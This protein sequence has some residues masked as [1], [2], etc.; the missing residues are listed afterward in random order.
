MADKQGATSS[1]YSTIQR[2]INTEQIT[3]ISYRDYFKIIKPILDLSAITN[4]NEQ[5]ID[6]I[7]VTI[8]KV[9]KNLQEQ[10]YDIGDQQA[11]I[12]ACIHS[13]LDTTRQHLWEWQLDD[14]NP[15]IDNLVCN[16]LSAFVHVNL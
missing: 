10:D 5:A 6:H 8:H 9:H 12:I 3:N 13:K 16:F 11:T 1:N 4:I 14:I 7:V 15:T 2:T